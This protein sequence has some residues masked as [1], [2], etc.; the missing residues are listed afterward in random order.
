[1]YLL[2]AK[3]LLSERLQAL[4]SQDYE[5]KPR[6]D[7]VI[8]FCADNESLQGLIESF[9]SVDASYA[10]YATSRAEGPG[11]QEAHVNQQAYFTVVTRFVCREKFQEW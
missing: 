2:S 7:H 11:L 9:G 3:D 8:R 10:H 5:L 6:E 4:A 1:M